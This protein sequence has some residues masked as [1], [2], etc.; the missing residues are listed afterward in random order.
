MVVYVCEADIVKTTK[1]THLHHTDV[2]H[3]NQPQHEHKRSQRD[4]QGAKAEMLT[5][6]SGDVMPVMSNGCIRV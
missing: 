2:Y 3:N 6:T 1:H 4:G 5:R